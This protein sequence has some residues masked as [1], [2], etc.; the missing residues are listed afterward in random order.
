MSA[1]KS[2]EIKEGLTKKGFLPEERDHTYLFL[3]IF[4]RPH[5]STTSWIAQCP[6]K[7]ISECLKRREF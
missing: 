6:I 1:R 4:S 3:H 5:N 7:T 2:R